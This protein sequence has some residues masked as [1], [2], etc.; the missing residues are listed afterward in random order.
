[1]RNRNRAPDI[2]APA[3]SALL[4]RIGRLDF[5]GRGMALTVLAR[6]PSM[7]ASVDDAVTYAAE[8]STSATAANRAPAPVPPEPELPDPALAELQAEFRE[9]DISEG[10]LSMFYAE[11]RPTG[12]RVHGEDT[13]DLR[14]AIRAV[15]QREE[16]TA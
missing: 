14:D 5:V 2:P 7:A 1:V 11:H 16:W 15:I 4:S 6:L 9:W 8:I 12:R 10:M 3:A 13:V